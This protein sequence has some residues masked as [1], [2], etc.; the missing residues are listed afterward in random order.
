M[1]KTFLFISLTFSLSVVGVN[2]QEVLTASGGASITVEKNA[3]M[4]V[5]GGMALEK[6]SFL[7]NEGTVVIAKTNKSSADFAD[8]TEDRYNYGTGKFIF[9]GEGTQSIRTNNQIGFIEVD[10]KGLNLLSDINANNWNLKNGTVNTGS[11]YAVSTNAGNDAITTAGDNINFSK[12]WFNGNLR[13]YIKP[14]N[15]N[16]YVLPVGDAYRVKICE[17]ANLNRNPLTGI[18]YIDVSFAR[19]Q[20]F[21]DGLKATENGLNYKAVNR[22]GMWNIVPD[23]KPVSGNYDLK[24]S[25]SDFSGLADNRFALLNRTGTSININDWLVPAGSILPADGSVGRTV[26]GGFARRNHISVFNQFAIADMAAASPDMVFMHKVYPD[27]VTNNEFFIEVKNYRLNGFKLFSSEGKEVNVSSS[28]MK[29]GLVKVSLP[30]SFAKGHYIV[31]L[32]TDKGFR[33]SKIIVL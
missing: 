23:A 24:L 5:Y 6:N 10:N 3:G 4:F 7:R 25:V 29:N 8:N 31:Q 16:N 26:A 32:N 17:M 18:K 19:P 2:A 22:S 14:A 21:T 30:T 9:Y 20:G 11:F 12:S 33:S 15:V 28:L 13:Q 27:P 1:K